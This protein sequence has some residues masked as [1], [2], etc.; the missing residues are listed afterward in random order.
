MAH[1][2]SDL[3]PDP[4]PIDEEHIRKAADAVTE[5]G[6]EAFRPEFLRWTSE[7]N[8]GMAEVVWNL[9]TLA[10]SEQEA[11]VTDVL[12]D[13]QAL[14]DHLAKVRRMRW[15]DAD[16]LVM[17]WQARVEGERVVFMFDLW[18]DAQQ[19]CQPCEMTWIAR[20]AGPAATN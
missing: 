6:I 20:V 8:L 2:D 9:R 19:F 17:G 1:A 15:P 11:V 13:M 3:S 14:H 12:P 5:F 4:T 16:W 10:R 7:V 18:W